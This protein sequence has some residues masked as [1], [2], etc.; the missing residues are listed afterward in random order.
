[1][2]EQNIPRE[3]GIFTGVISGVRENK[4]YNDSDSKDVEKYVI[5][6]NIVDYITNSESFAFKDQACTEKMTYDELR[7]AYIKGAIVIVYSSE[8][9]LVYITP[10]CFM[11]Q[12][13]LMEDETYSK[14]GMIEF[15][16]PG[17][18]SG[19]TQLVSAEAEHMGK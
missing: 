1:M 14:V 19:F 10:F 4:I 8:Y 12:D 5:F 13:V 6:A 9:G 15:V 16:S 2:T 18:A 7:N 17:L 3:E 11:E